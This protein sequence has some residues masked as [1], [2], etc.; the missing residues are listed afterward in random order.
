MPTPHFTQTHFNIILL[1]IL[2]SLKWNL[3]FTFP[4]HKSLLVL[5][6]S[7]TKYKLQQ[8]LPPCFHHSNN[9]KVRTSC[10]VSPHAIFRN[11]FTFCRSQWPCVLKRGSAA[12][13]LLG[14]RVQIPP[15][16]WTS[17]CFVCCM[18]SGRGLCD[19]LITR[20]EDLNR[21]WCVWVYS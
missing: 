10:K 9:I 19:E 2:S 11:I 8:F 15:V 18:L 13:G 1:S 6:T 4:S 16:A 20:L 17:I 21:L 3:T 14:L 12:A 5:C 7:S